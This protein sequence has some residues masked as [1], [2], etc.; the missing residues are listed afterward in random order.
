M[1]TNNI[2]LVKKLIGVLCIANL[3]GL[4]SCSDEWD[5][6]Y[7]PSE[8][9]ASSLWE[10]IIAESDL[11]N[12]AK[13]LK[14]TGFDQK[15]SGSQTYSVFA[16]TNDGLSDSQADSLVSEFLKQKEAGVRE[17]DNTVVRQFIQNHVSMY[18]HPVSSLT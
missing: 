14:A 13:V 4:V 2:R 5:N 18:R 7:I 17:N 8:A 3:L 1:K 10:G 6:H 11:S 16:L 15:L 9:N 12:F